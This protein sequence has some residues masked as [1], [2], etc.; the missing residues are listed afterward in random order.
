MKHYID[1][2]VDCVF[3]AILGSEAHKNLLVHFLNAILEPPPGQWIE[4]VILQN[5][6]NPQDFIGDKLSIV[7]V[8]AIDQRGKQYQVEI[9][10]ATYIGLNHRMLYNWS[11]LYKEQIKAGNDYS[12]LLPT[13]SIW[14]LNDNLPELA[15]SD[16]Y[17]HHFQVLDPQNQ[18]YLNDHLNIHVL[19][20]KKWHDHPIEIET[21]KQQW[22]YF[23]REGKQ[24]DVD[25]PP[26]PLQHSPIMERDRPLQIG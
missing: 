12:E 25:S 20:L 15:G 9:Q 16:R 26:K 24:I 2:T 21:A 1:P 17:H 6:Y 8:K 11:Q 3:K 7:D 18:I 19:E 5:P 23:F 10:I 4:S 14:I 22:L 13:T